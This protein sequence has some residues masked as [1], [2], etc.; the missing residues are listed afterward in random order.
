MVKALMW[1]LRKALLEAGDEIEEVFEGQVGMQAADDVKLGDGFGVAGSR[2]LERLF[3]RHG[4]AGRGRPS[5]GRRRT[6]AGR[7]ADIGGV[8]VAVD[9]EVGHVAVQALAHVIGQPAD[10]EKV[11]EP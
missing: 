3:E 9:V 6:A 11:G 5:C 8:D 4:V 1:T 10:G 7:H 2:S